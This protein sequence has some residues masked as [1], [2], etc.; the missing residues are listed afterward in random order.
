VFRLTRGGHYVL[1]NARHL[2]DGEKS[3]NLN[4]EAWL[5][6]ANVLYL[7]PVSGGA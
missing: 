3:F 1:A 6:H 7:Q 5:P 4:G 2:E